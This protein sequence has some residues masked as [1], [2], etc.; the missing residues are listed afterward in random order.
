MLADLRTRYQPDLGSQP[1][2]LPGVSGA[3]VVETVMRSARDGGTVLIAPSSLATLLPSMRK[4][5]ADFIDGLVPVAG[6]GELLLAFIVGPAVPEHIRTL[7]G[8]VEWV[9]SHPASNSFGVPALGTAPHFVGNELARLADLS[10]H[11]VAYKGTLAL[12]QDVQSGSVPAAVTM[13]PADPRTNVE[14]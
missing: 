14:S 3:L 10:L 9:R 12:A 4:F 13:I 1:V 6:I 7:F 11:A 5:P 2:A 8:Y